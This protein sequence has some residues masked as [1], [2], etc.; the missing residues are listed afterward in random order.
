MQILICRLVP[1]ARVIKCGD[2]QSEA[3]LTPYGQPMW[4]FVAGKD[5]RHTR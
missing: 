1:V 2:C 5:S 3:A 4:C